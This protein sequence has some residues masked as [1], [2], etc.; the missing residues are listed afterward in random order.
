MSI[1]AQPKQM[2][3]SGRGPPKVNHPI[4]QLSSVL[5]PLSGADIVNQPTHAPLYNSWFIG[6]DLAIFVAEHDDYDF[7]RMTELKTRFSATQE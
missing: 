4:L 3:K 5:R 1:L 6:L 7:A 2:L